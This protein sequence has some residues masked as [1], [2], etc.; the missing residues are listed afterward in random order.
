MEFRILGPLEVTEG[1]HPVV[2]Q[3]A[4]QRALLAALLL[5][6]NEVVSS[7][8][9]ID[10]LWG[11]EPPESGVTALQ[12]RVSQLRKALDKSASLLETRSPGYVLHVEQ[13][14]LDLGRFE[15]LATEAAEAEPERAADLLR[16]ALSLWRGPPLAEFAYDTFAQPAINRLEELR[17]T[18]LE[19]RVEADLALGRHAQLVGE[20]EALV[21][22]HPLRERLRAQLMLALYRSGRQAEALEVY[23]S[24]RRTLVDALGIEPTP[25]LQELEGAILRQDPALELARLPATERS[26]LVVSR[27]EARFPALVGLAAPLACRPPKELILTRAAA[28]PE[29]LPAVAATLEAERGRLIAEGL[30][31]RAAAFVSES[32]GADLVRLATEQDVDLVLV[33]GPSD[34]LE[35]PV[36]ESLLADSPCDV[37]VLAGHDLRTGPVFVPFVGA[38]HD[39]TAVELAAWLAGALGERLLFAGPR[40]G[41]GGRDASRLL[42]SASLAVQRALGVAA[43][44]LLLDPG[45]EALLAAAGSACAVVLGLPDRWQSKGL[46]SVR[47]ALADGARAPVLLVRRGLRPGGLAPPAS[48]TRFTWS[49]RA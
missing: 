33:D 39:W 16:E 18:V 49:L 46:G 20:L 12:V 37:A 21:V 11:A 45:P 28:S 26:L 3:G 10:E 15:R 35:D 30:P 6:A 7:D 23:Q 1:G 38:E 2:L 9:L 17:L 48:L 19:R 8:R 13:G 22:D 31:A 5:H 25:A 41:A 42:A 43:E 40:E 32:P 14:A 34:V 24:T 4:K 47:A 36:V 27:D 29:G 44:P